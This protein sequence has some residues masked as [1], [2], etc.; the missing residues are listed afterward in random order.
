MVASAV[1][2]ASM[3]WRSGSIANWRYSIA[4]DKIAGCP[5]GR[6]CLPVRVR[7]WRPAPLCAAQPVGVRRLQRFILLLRTAAPP[8]APCHPR[9]HAH[10]AER[11]SG[12]TPPARPRCRACVSWAAPAG[13]SLP[14]PG[15][16]AVLKQ[17]RQYPSPVAR[18]RQRQRQHPPPPVPF[19]SVLSQY[20]V[21]MSKC[22]RKKKKENRPPRRRSTHDRPI[23]RRGVFIYI[24][25]QPVLE[26]STILK[27]TRSTA[28]VR[29]ES[30]WA[31][32]PIHRCL[33]ARPN[34]HGGRF[35][36]P[37]QS[38]IEDSTNTFIYNL[39]QMN[40][41]EYIRRDRAFSLIP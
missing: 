7:V 20:E 8:H 16:R 37:P 13:P 10:G 38:R 1:Q 29:P 5:S 30:A 6:H 14:G 32:I 2:S 18:C 35:A 27:T 26:N 15:Y 40:Y 17:G 3:A 34:N 11:A 12:A 24:A 41:Y 39:N 25:L 21:N 31:G 9:K 36:P 22:K 28:R 23:K 4:I 33:R 19:F